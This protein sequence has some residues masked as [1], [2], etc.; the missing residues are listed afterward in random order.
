MAGASHFY[1]TA[2]THAGTS[3]MRTDKVIED[4]DSLA[5]IQAMLPR[6]QTVE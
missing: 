3:S 2:R 6:E 1:G 5:T 4:A